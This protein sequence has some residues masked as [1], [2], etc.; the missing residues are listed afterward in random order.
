[1]N[2]LPP[3]LSGTDYRNCRVLPCH[4]G[5]PMHFRKEAAKTCLFMSAPSKRRQLA[6]R[7]IVSFHCAS[8]LATVW[9][10]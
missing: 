10:R 7:T 8:T 6:S 9:P 1:M 3:I 2:T 5:F 4:E